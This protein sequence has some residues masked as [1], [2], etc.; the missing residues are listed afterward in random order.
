MNVL[1]VNYSQ[2]HDSGTQKDDFGIKIEEN[3]GFG[4]IARQWTVY[5]PI[6]K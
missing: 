5:Q 1:A 4:L 3:S 2:N 6:T